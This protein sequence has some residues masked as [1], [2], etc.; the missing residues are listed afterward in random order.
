MTDMQQQM[1]L[2]SKVKGIS[3][4]TYYRSTDGQMLQL[5]NITVLLFIIIIS[6]WL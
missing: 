5:N 1:V 6:L 3:S 2:L 4:V